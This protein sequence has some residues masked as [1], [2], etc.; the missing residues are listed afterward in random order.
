MTT[1]I[2]VN[3]Q[4][5]TSQIEKLCQLHNRKPEEITLVG[6]S[7]TKP[8]AS[9]QSAVE[10][11]LMHIGENK[12]QE[13]TEKMEHLTDDR[14]IWH[15]VGQLQT[16]KIKYLADR[17]NWIQSVSRKKELKE[18]EKR[19]TQAGRVINILIQVNISGEDQKSGCDPE[20]LHTLLDYASGL[21]HVATRGLM[22]IATLTENRDQ[23][24]REFGSLAELK[25]QY[26]QTYPSPV[27]L[28]HLSMGMTHDMDIAIEM[29]ATMIRVG[30]AIFGAREG[31]P[32][33]TKQ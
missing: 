9:I 10:N 19:A 15:M 23:I 8:V 6:I 3:L 30:T 29:G 18:I 25:S 27:T 12:A 2:A 31:Q 26:R 17:V 1:D 24:R 11:G 28:E 32:A 33:P 22:G 7:K 13:L 14:I 20:E 16:N 4:K 5:V 21:K